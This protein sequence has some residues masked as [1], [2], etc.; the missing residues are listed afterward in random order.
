M[1]T[2]SFLFD[3]VTIILPESRIDSQLPIS[4]VRKN[5]CPS[6]SVRA[7]KRCKAREYYNQLIAIPAKEAFMSR[8][9]SIVAD[10]CV[11]A[12]SAYEFFDWYLDTYNKLP[13]SDRITTAIMRLKESN[14]SDGEITILKGL[15]PISVF[16][17]WE[18]HWFD[19]DR[20]TVCDTNMSDSCDLQ[21][22]SLDDCKST[23]KTTNDCMVVAGS[24]AI[25]HCQ[26]NHSCEIVTDYV[27]HVEDGVKDILVQPSDTLSCKHYYGSMDSKSG[28]E[29]YALGLL[30]RLSSLAIKPDTSANVRIYN[31]GK[32]CKEL[33]SQVIEVI[34]CRQSNFYDYIMSDT[35]SWRGKVPTDRVVMV[36]NPYKYSRWKWRRWML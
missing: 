14:F 15:V 17:T 19:S 1:Y 2:N 18:E 24:E 16:T 28:E 30:P 29:G 32:L 20:V 22:H 27:H 3:A 35:Q 25:M 23:I 10:K 21:E 5:Y 11:D 6:K 9:I 7:K 34:K 33:T 13:E 12:T 36:I 26:S 4:N 31:R 8:N